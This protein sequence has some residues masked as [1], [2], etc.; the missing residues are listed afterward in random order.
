MFDTTLR[1]MRNVLRVMRNRY[2]FYSIHSIAFNIQKQ[3]L[4]LM[5]IVIYQFR[6]CI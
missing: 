3:V 5:S 6:L 1:F 2:I 4:I